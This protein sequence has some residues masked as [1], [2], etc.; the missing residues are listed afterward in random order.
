VPFLGTITSSDNQT[1]K[2]VRSLQ[3]K[4][5][6]RYREKRY[7]VE[8]SRSVAHAL[9]RGVRPVFVLYSEAYVAPR[10]SAVT[11]PDT[12][13]PEADSTSTAMRGALVARLAD[14]GASVWQV[15]PT[16]FDALAD[17][18]TPQGIMAV[19]PMPEADAALARSADLILVLDNIRDPGNLGTMLRTAQA[20]GVQSVLLSPGCVDPYAPKVVRSAMGA[21][22]HLPL[23]P[24]LDW[25]SIEQIL[26]DKQRLL[27][28]MHAPVALW[29][30]DWT[31][32]TALIV[33]SEAFGAGA[34]ARR[35]ATTSVRLP[36]AGDAESLNAAVA[37][38]IL[39][40]EAQ[41]QRHLARSA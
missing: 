34:E 40:Y 21:H 29:D 1:L 3:Q 33:G 23:L 35:L 6:V 12:E 41:R 31:R 27:A 25:L 5:R 7:V 19:V 4:K 8:G 9:E 28:D 30:V 14:S 20:A 37:T 13:A 39:L 16:L 2:Y 24:D 32:P 17:T 36:M 22:L 11:S 10:A 15:L 26:A 18:V 38:A